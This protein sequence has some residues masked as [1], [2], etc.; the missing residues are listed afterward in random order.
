MLFVYVIAHDM[1][2]YRLPRH[3]GEDTTSAVAV[4]AVDRV[5]AFFASIFDYFLLTSEYFFYE[6][7]KPGVMTSLSILNRTNN[8]RGDCTS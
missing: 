5:L 1:L 8:H 7:M 4:V 2:V 3:S 6:K